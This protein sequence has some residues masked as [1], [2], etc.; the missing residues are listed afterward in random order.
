MKMCEHG[1]QYCTGNHWK[2]IGNF[3]TL[4][5]SLKANCERMFTN[6]QASVRIP[7]HSQ[8]S[9]RQRFSCQLCL[10]D[11]V[12]MCLHFLTFVRFIN[13]SLWYLEKRKNIE[14]RQLETAR[15]HW[16]NTTGAAGAVASDGKVSP[17]WRWNCIT[18]TR[19]K[20]CG[21]RQ[22]Q[23]CCQGVMKILRIALWKLEVPTQ[24]ATDSK[25][26][27]PENK[28][29]A[30]SL[31]YT[32]LTWIQLS[33]SL[34][35]VFTTSRNTVSLAHKQLHATSHCCFNHDSVAT[36]PH[37]PFSNQKHPTLS[38]IWQKDSFW[39]WQCSLPNSCTAH[40]NGFHTWFHTK[41]SQLYK[42]NKRIFRHARANAAP[43]WT[44]SRCVDIDDLW[45]SDMFRSYQLFWPTSR[46][47]FALPQLGK[48]RRVKH[49]LTCYVQE[50]TDVF[51]HQ[52]EQ[53]SLSSQKLYPTEVLWRLS[54]SW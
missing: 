9:N 30:T 22:R 33:R 39:Y 18:E 34:L 6:F 44:V 17:L 12:C 13:D 26:P 50:P 11:F 7:R 4:L 16:T 42:R 14:E 48:R 47:Y 46:L 10:Y 38:Q 31:E 52:L 27:T 54:C 43:V 45:H 2:C 1:K 32:L 20:L 3:S 25:L 5:R 40:Q 21:D 53:R 8:A 51:F 41:Y 36:K 49:L 35:L 24:V 28:R 29:P 23:P 37:G 19:S 15:K